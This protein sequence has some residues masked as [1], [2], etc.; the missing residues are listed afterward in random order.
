MGEAGCCRV[1]QYIQ[2]SSEQM[3]QG[4]EEL[5]FA[6]RVPASRGD[7][8]SLRPLPRAVD[9]DAACEAGRDGANGKQL[10]YCA[11]EGQ[12]VEDNADDLANL[13]LFARY[14][15]GI[16]SMRKRCTS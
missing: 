5:T 13:R 3:L 16:A 12:K 4:L 6:V 15:H 9:H 1:I 2:N 10:K 11:K 8:A 7:A 14:L